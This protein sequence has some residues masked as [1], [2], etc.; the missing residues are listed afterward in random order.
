[1]DKKAKVFLIVLVLICLVCM[2][3]A[4]YFSRYK[5]VVRPIEGDSM[6]PNVHDGDSVLIYRTNRVKYGDI[7]ILDSKVYHRILIK[8]VIGLPGDKIR[9]KYNLTQGIYQIYRNGALLD[10]DYIKEPITRSYQELELTVPAD[11]FFYLGDN[12]NYSSDSH[13]NGGITEE[14]SLIQGKVLLRYNGMRVAFLEIS[15]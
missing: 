3:T 11:Q 8:R 9:I 7:V 4:F 1:M 5:L 10:E 2:S 12:R 14:I 13:S 6:E 15:A